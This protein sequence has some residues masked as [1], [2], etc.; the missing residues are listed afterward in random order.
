M[1]TPIPF[2]D[3]QAQ[4]NRL[5]N[6]IEQAIGR[7]LDHG[8]FIM[9]PEIKELEDNLSAFCGAAHSLGCSNGTD[10]LVL[11]L[12]A[13][14][15]GP[16]DAVLCPSFT[17]AATAEA[18]ALVGASP[19]FVDIL[20]DTFNMDPANLDSAMEAALAAGLRPKG[21]IPVDL[22][23]LPADYDGLEAFARQY[24]LWIIADAAQSFGAAYKGRKVGSMGDMATTSFFPAKPLGCYGDGGAVFTGDEAT[25]R[26]LHSL[27]VHGQGTDRYDNIRIGINGRLDTLQ[28]A[29]LLLKLEI[30]PDEIMARNRVADRYNQ[31]LAQV[32]VVPKVPQGLTSTWAQYTLRFTA[33]NRDFI[34]ATLKDQ[35]IPT[36][37]YYP[38]PLHKQSAYH[39]YPVAGEK[40]PV[41]DQMAREVLSLPMHPYLDEAAQD[42]IIQAVLQ[43]K[44]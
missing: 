20:P 23:G 30:F 9:G 19:V 29:I 41:T 22:F 16:G 14:G 32:A 31:A 38:R 42:R 18:V 25:Q 11:A 27:R 40:L 34:A 10:A 43:A 13:K 39:H 33:G 37:I 17:F 5:G 6:R 36:A 35:A 12:M 7:V 15:A 8:A 2:I 21:I 4:R 24:K 28:A 26:L 3:L 1:T 44:S